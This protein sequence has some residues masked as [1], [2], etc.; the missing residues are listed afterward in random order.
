MV[1]FI[2][3]SCTKVDVPLPPQWG[4]YGEQSS[5][6]LA[7]CSALLVSEMIPREWEALGRREDRGWEQDGKG[8]E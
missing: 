7:D 5:A 4:S 6:P 3:I 1:S 8:E 2:H